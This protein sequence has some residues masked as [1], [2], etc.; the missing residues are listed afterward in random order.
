MFCFPATLCFTF[1]PTVKVTVGAPCFTCVQTCCRCLRTVNHRDGDNRIH[2][3]DSP[4][5]KT[6]IELHLS[7][8]VWK[9]L[10]SEAQTWQT[11]SP[12]ATSRT[13]LIST[14]IELSI[15]ESFSKI[16]TACLLMAL[17]RFLGVSTEFR[18]WW[19][20]EMCWT[21]GVVFLW[22]GAFGSACVPTVDHQQP[23]PEEE[24][25]KCLLILQWSSLLSDRVWEQA[26]VEEEK[27]YC[28]LVTA[29]TKKLANAVLYLS[30]HST[31]TSLCFGTQRKTYLL[32]RKI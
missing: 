19:W 31:N 9:I 18:G 1:A 8:V 7:V 30:R 21:Q 2:V 23:G 32:C 6:F 28:T 25:N 20:D 10:K 14:W 12:W 13:L 26:C 17:E 22:V 16:A 11:F 29:Q 4:S 24:L 5:S 15:L 3:M 27:N